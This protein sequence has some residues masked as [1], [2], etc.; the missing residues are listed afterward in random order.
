MYR[1]ACV[2][3]VFLVVKVALVFVS[4]LQLQFLYEQKIF[5]FLKKQQ[6]LVLIL[7]SFHISKVR[8]RLTVCN[9]NHSSGW[10]VL[11]VHVW[12][13]KLDGALRVGDYLHTNTALMKDKQLVKVK[14]FCCCGKFCDNLNHSFLISWEGTEASGKSWP[15]AVWSHTPTG[16]GVFVWGS[17]CVCSVVLDKQRQGS[18]WL[19]N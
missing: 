6:L 19:T 7:L 2:L 14:V 11:V 9:G 4:L 16:F 17:V 10:T 8:T 13:G 5:F 1:N 15:Q 18:C 12:N 3:T